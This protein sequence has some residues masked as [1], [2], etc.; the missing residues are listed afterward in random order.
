METGKYTQMRWKR[1]CRCGFI[2]SLKM[3]TADK[4]M[5][6][7]RGGK[8]AETMRGCGLKGSVACEFWIHIH[9]PCIEISG[10]GCLMALSELLQ[11]RE[12]R[13]VLA[14]NLRWSP[15]ELS[16]PRPAHVF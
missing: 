9:G 14:A 15:T 3:N 13:P 16:D 12:L 8:R 4:W 11:W 1:C 6:N 7:T 2:L 10:G 5:M